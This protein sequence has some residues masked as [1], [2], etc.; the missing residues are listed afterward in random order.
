MPK[1]SRLGVKIIMMPYTPI[2]LVGH[3]RILWWKIHSS[4]RRHLRHIADQN[5]PGS[6]RSVF[7][8]PVSQRYSQSIHFYIRIY[9]QPSLSGGAL[10]R[11]PSSRS[12]AFAAAPSFPLAKEV[13]S[14]FRPASLTY[15]AHHTQWSGLKRRC[16]QG[17]LAL[18]SRSR[19]WRTWD[20][21]PCNFNL[22]FLQL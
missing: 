12:K 9:P 6:N 4:D 3:I 17:R 15:V 20:R 7:F 11:G 8:L 13:R 10:F 19:E 16:F 1:R 22:F 21:F 14:H 18:S 2:H 5:S